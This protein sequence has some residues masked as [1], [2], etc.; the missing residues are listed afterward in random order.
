MGTIYRSLM[1]VFIVLAVFS[2][3]YALACLSARDCNIEKFEGAERKPVNALADFHFRLPDHGEEGAVANVYLSDSRPARIE[4]II[5]GKTTQTKIY[6]ETANGASG[7]LV[8]YREI[9]FPH[10]AGEGGTIHVASQ[11]ANFV[12]CEGFSH[13]YPDS[14]KLLLQ[15]EEAEKLL[16]EIRSRALSILRNQ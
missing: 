3:Q 1:F 16:F 6:Y 7:Y 2:G 8:T 15:I 12:I 14:S 13:N 4:V 10:P 9:Y 11:T 5:Y